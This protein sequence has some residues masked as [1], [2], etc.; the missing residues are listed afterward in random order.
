VLWAFGGIKTGDFRTSDWENPYRWFFCG[1]I[2]KLRGGKIR[3]KRRYSSFFT[4][5]LDF[6]NF[7]FHIPTLDFALINR[8]MV[9]GSHE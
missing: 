5:F 3:E 4:I 1:H 9:F 8:R 6:L 2:E 7:L